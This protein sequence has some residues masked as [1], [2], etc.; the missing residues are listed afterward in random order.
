MGRAR[1]M[2][3]RAVQ[4]DGLVSG[5]SYERLDQSYP[6]VRVEGG[7]VVRETDGKVTL[8]V[9]ASVYSGIRVDTDPTLS[10]DAAMAVFL[11]DT[12]A[13]SAPRAAPELVILPKDA[14]TF[15]LAYRITAF[16]GH[17]MPVVFVNAK[18]G[19]VELRYNNLRSQQATAQ[20][21]SGVLASQGLVPSDQ[22]K[23][24]CAL[25]GPRTSPGTWSDP[26]PS[27]RTT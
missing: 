17:E 3:L 8:S 27:R 13:T 21:G 15:V 22:K 5:R 1:D 12:G 26:P 23:V 2:R 10:P 9:T 19:G 24:A 11:E 18:T 25:Q 16:V 14:G 4:A 6:G 7:E 20:I